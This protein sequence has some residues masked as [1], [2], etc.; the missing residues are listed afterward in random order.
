LDVYSII[1]YSGG[2][3]GGTGTYGSLNWDYSGPSRVID[4]NST[5]AENDTLSTGSSGILRNSVNTQW[6]IGAISK[7]Y[8][9]ISETVKS[10]IGIDWRLF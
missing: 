8:Y 1:Y 4:W 6:T 5:I 10:S 2:K 3:G 7:A 9:Q